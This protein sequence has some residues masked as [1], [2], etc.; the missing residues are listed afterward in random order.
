MHLGKAS[1]VKARC[2]HYAPICLQYSG[3]G[4]P[5]SSIFEDVMVMNWSSVLQK[6]VLPSEA[7]EEKQ[8]GYS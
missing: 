3:K 2:P 5:H 1:A 4:N 8:S 7:E 6:R